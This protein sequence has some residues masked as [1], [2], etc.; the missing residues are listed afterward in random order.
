MDC[1][2][3]FLSRGCDECAEVRAVLSIEAAEDDDFRG[4]KGQG[5]L[6][7]GALSDAAGREMLDV[8]GYEERCT[9]LLSTMD[10]M[11]MDDSEKI[12]RYLKDNGMA[13]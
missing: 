1:D 7:F 8:F 10:G 11:V 3:L 2:R 6:V 5:L 4:V 12:I 13:S 9:P